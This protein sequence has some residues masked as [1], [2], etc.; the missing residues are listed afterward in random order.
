MFSSLD[1]NFAKSAPFSFTSNP[2]ERLVVC[3]MC[4]VSTPAIAGCADRPARVSI[5][6]DFKAKRRGH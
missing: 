5:L 1:L 2:E 4:S 6:L 3:T